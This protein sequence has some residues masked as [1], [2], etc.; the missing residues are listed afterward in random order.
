MNLARRKN[1]YEFGKKT[2]VVLTDEQQQKKYL[3]DCKRKY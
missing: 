1:A 3:Y 2:A